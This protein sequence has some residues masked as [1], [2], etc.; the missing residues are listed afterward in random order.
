MASLLAVGVLLA[1][2]PAS[3]RAL[4]SDHA[5]TAENVNRQGAD[6]T[7][8]Y[9]FPSPDDST[10]VVLAMDVWGLIPAG[11]TRSFDPNV[12]YQFHID[13]TGDA[14]E[15]LVI[16]AKFEGIGASQRVKIAGPSRPLRTGTTSIFTTYNPTVGTFNQTFNPAA[17]IRAFAGLREDPFFLDLNQFYAIFPDRM[18]PL[19]GKQVDL[20][21]PNTP[22]QSGWRPP[23]TAQDFFNNI[24]VLS[25]V[26]EVPRSRLGSGVIGVWMTT[27]V[28]AGGNT[29]RQQDRLA[30]PLPN[31]VLATVTD[32]DHESI[33]KMTPVED[34][35]RLKSEI[36]SFLTFPAGRSTA[37]KN[38]IE[39]VLVPDVLKAD[40]S[41]S[42]PAA[43]LGVETGGA[44]GG[45]FGGRK[46]IDDVVDISLGIIFGNTV[47]AL[48]LAPDDGKELPSFTSDNVGPQGNITGA[49]PFPFLPPPA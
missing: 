15:D 43:Y 37:I 36:E 3:P 7:D 18:T 22:Q 47:P 4:G 20:A 24:N 13:N 25:I 34:S 5:D 23:G 17:G 14:V 11:Q 27:N 31:E 28:S 8:L 49:L 2:A 45:T 16:Q 39:S 10:K 1:S 33:N 32:R 40:M 21:N 6:L 29:Y 48:G 42:G 26:V 38:V 9:I 35:G 44:T 46:L 19:T 30:R 12:L 41:Q